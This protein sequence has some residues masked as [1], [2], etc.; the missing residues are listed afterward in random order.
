MIAVNR[1]RAG[2]MGGVGEWG[3]ECSVNG[4][5]GERLL[6][7]FSPTFFLK[8]LTEGSVTTEAGSLFQ[9]FTTLSFGGGSHL[10]VPWRAAL[11]SR[12]V[13]SKW[14]LITNCMKCQGA[15]LEQKRSWRYAQTTA[16]CLLILATPICC[17]CVWKLA[18]TV[19]IRSLHFSTRSRLDNRAVKYTPYILPMT[20][21]HE[22]RL[23]RREIHLQNLMYHF[24]SDVR[25]A[26]ELLDWMPKADEE[27][28][29]DQ[30]WSW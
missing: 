30:E 15:V 20:H 29:E 9:H 28:E 7:K 8:T 24:V 17:V 14:S 23:R 6:S 13:S 1:W 21:K 2:G 26:K 10:G 22:K 5:G 12:S 18:Y 11:L 4:G 19:G 3:N 27:G 25:F 16:G